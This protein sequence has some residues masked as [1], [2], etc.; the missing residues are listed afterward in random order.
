MPIDPNTKAT[1]SFEGTAVSLLD[2]L[3]QLTG[4]PVVQA[5]TSAGNGNARTRKPSSPAAT[6]QQAETGAAA[7]DAGAS[8]SGDAG[9]GA[10]QD[11]AAPAN[12]AAS[13]VTEGQATAT[14]GATAPAA[15]ATVTYDDVTK[16]TLALAR[17][18]GREAAVKVLG[19][20][21]VDHGSKLTPEQ[22]A[23][24]IAAA[25]AALQPELA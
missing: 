21:G 15:K 3:Q 6:A 11:A 25:T 9:N 12:G 1:L 18:K 10:S 16:A 22:W 20:F 5:D 24:Y 23:P 14:P 4:A 19:T 17:A 8:S 13:T 2:I 7:S